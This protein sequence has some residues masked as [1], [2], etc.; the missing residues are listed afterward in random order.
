MQLDGFYLALLP[1]TRHAGTE[2]TITGG[3]TLNND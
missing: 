3:E 1:V 2:T